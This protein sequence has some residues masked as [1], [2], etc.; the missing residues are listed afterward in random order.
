VPLDEQGRSGAL[1]PLPESRALLMQAARTV[2]ARR[3]LDW[4]PPPLKVLRWGIAGAS[5]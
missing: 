3:D 2:P 5:V 1:V 4:L